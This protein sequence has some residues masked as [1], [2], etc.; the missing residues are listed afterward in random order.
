[1]LEAVISDPKAL[2]HL[3]RSIPIQRIATADEVAKPILWLLSAEASFVT[4]ACL[5]VSGGGFLIPA[6]SP[7]L[8]EE[9]HSFPGMLRS[10]FEKTV[11]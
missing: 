11:S 7:S 1:M 10:P 9:G 5:D 3:S 2:A 6:M 4:G 8:S